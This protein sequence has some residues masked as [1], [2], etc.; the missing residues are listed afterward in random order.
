MA[1]LYPFQT[2][3]KKK[4]EEMKNRLQFNRMPKLYASREEATEALKYYYRD[5]SFIPLI[6]EP[7][8]VRYY[9]ADGKKQAILAIGKAT[10]KTADDKLNREY[11]II[12]T[13]EIN[14]NVADASFSAETALDLASAP[15]KDIANYRIILKNMIGDGGI[16]MEDGSYF[17]TDDPTGCGLYK[18][19]PGTN[20]ISAATSL[21]KADYILDQAIG[22][23][24]ENVTELSGVTVGV[25]ESVNELSAATV[26]LSGV[27][28]EFSASTVAELNALKDDVSELSGA[29]DTLLNNIKEA[30][31]LEPDGTYEHKHDANF[32]DDATSLFEADTILDDTLAELSANTIAADQAIQEQITRLDNKKI[33][34]QDAITV[35]TVSGD[36]TIAL[37]ISAQDKVLTQDQFGLKSN[38]TLS[39]S[40]AD[41]TI[42]LYGK[43]N[44]VLGQ[45][46]TNDFIKDGMIDEVKVFTP[47]QQWIDDNPQYSYAN[48]EAGKPYLWITFNTDSEK[49]PKDVFLRLDSLVDTYTVD[50]ESR[51]YMSINDYVVSLNVDVDGG[52]AS[53]DYTKGISAVTANIISATG[54]NVGQQGTY[55]HHDRTEI[56]RY[57]N[58]LDEADVLLDAAVSN[59]SGMVIDLSGDV[60]SYID[61][62]TEGYDEKIEELDERVDELEDK[63]NELSAGTVSALSAVTETVHT[64]VDSGLTILSGVV[65]EY[66]ET[67]LSGISGDIISALSGNLVTYVDE[68]ISNLSG[69]VISYVDNSIST[70][71][72]DVISYVDES[73]ENLSGAILDYVYENEEVTAAA[74]NDLNDRKADK[75]YVDEAIG[76][77][78]S[79]FT[80][81]V[82]SELDSASTNPVENRA[83]YQV[84]VDNEEVV[85][86]AINDLNDR[87][88]KNTSDIDELSGVTES[89][90]GVVS[91]MSAATNGTLTISVNGEE[92]GKYCPSASTVIDI[93][94]LVD[95]TGADILLTGYEL[96]SGTSIEELEI[97]E[98]D[99]VNEAFGKIQKQIIDN[100]KVTAA[101]F[102]DLNDR[103][104]SLSGEV[105]TLA[106]DVVTGISVNGGTVI[107]SENNV[108]N[109]QIEVPAVNN[110]FDGAEYVSSAKT[111]I[112]TH[113]HNT[114]SSIDATDFIKDGMLHSAY[115]VVSGGEKYIAF[116]FNEDAGKDTILLKVSD[117]A[118][119]YGAGSGITIANDDT[120][121]LKLANKGDSNYIKLDG[122]GLYLSG[123]SEMA[124][125]MT[126]ISAVTSSLTQNLQTV[127]GDV[128]ELSA[129]TTAISHN[130]QVVSGDVIELSAATVNIESG[131]TVLSA[132]VLDNE[133]VI[134][135]AFNDL[136]SRIIELSGGVSSE[137]E[138]LD[139]D[140]TVQI[141][142][143]AY[144]SATTDFSESTV[145]INTY[146]KY[147][148]AGT[149]TAM[150]FSEFLTVLEVSAD[151]TVGITSDS[152][153]LPKLPAG[154][155]KE[156]H[157]ILKNTSSSNVT[158]TVAT[159]SRVLCTGGNIMFIEGN[160]IGELNAL[161]TYDGTN[162]TFYI[163][164]T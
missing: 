71:S 116:E 26:A 49:S 104:I 122:D 2:I 101:A 158:V 14:E 24:N 102:N 11:H 118:K 8:V 156:A 124:T 3:Y 44:A 50:P 62:K 91:S 161:I 47:T 34:G 139:H 150:T 154:G 145:E 108:I 78:L 162:Y 93:E 90:S 72:G 74:L 19:Y 113:D 56:I 159:D 148:T 13:A 133:L 88:L 31:G 60:I 103:L 35:T 117:F 66:V 30:A 22:D 61:E 146:K 65:E 48:L 138:S 28:G 77:A 4:Y 140:V 95:V 135:A 94:A 10:G 53:Y 64:I 143:E 75:S 136:N 68:S 55:P 23:T 7:I 98:D 43:D 83:I 16:E 129:A 20:F 130:L 5:S 160:G 84:I 107:P 46:P 151:S 120:I 36:S 58:S 132:V 17:D 131:L 157:V 100:E 99:T 79:S 110:F 152:T 38:V 41:T 37:F 12:D 111:I 39:Y 51:H 82:D 85:S 164:T 57:A 97:T 128:I 9:D 153:L 123:I 15:T 147:T 18:V 126:V 1:F 106:D 115:T 54:L 114:V 45:I 42:Y 137:A 32:I 33:L 163:I 134:A 27:T 67:R 121:N 40:S 52:L 89:L 73:I 109:L 29:T 6:G 92:A 63:V 142:G 105:E 119:L 86:A 125:N 69:D 21:A 70:L 81:T 112:F 141:S 127:S 155:L 25:V 149:L 87:V 59:V 96:A 76:E 144:G 80:I